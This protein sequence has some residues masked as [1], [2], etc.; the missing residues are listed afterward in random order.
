MSIPGLES[1]ELRSIH[2]WSSDR[3]VVATAGQPA[4]IY[5]SRDAGKS[6]NK[7]YEIQSPQGFIDGLR[8][9]E[10]LF[11]LA[12]SDPVDGQLLVLK[13]EDGGDR[14]QPI[15]ASKLPAIEAGEA[16]FAASN[17]SLLVLGN[18]AWIGLGGGEAGPSH[19]FRT[20]DRGAT[21]QVHE[22]SFLR[23][24]PSAG[25]F[26]VSIDAEGRGLVVGGDYQ[27]ESSAENNIA[28]T[29]DGGKRWRTPQRNHPGGF[30]SCA[31]WVPLNQSPT[32]RLWLAC[33]PNG[34]D[35]SFD[36]EYWFPIS[37]EGFHAMFP[38]KDGT[39]WACGSQGRIARLNTE[40]LPG[41]EP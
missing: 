16:G 2:A 9:D 33:G 8:F 32:R 37:Q 1:T 36:R 25:I 12:F 17:S 21:W 18:S 15:E 3:V 20:A 19:I 13:S 35:G 7:T 30:R 5:Q 39:V 24:A 22:V 41:K 11:G 23:R 10:E 4:V 28:L 14:W 29:D 6:W 40:R 26:S 34:C 27:K 38:A 31:I